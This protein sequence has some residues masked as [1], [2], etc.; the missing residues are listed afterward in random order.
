MVVWND[1][2]IGH[3]GESSRGTARVLQRASLSR[4]VYVVAALLGVVLQGHPVIGVLQRV[5]W[6]RVPP[7]YLVLG[8]QLDV[9]GGAIGADRSHAVD[10][11]ARALL[12]NTCLGQNV[13]LVELAEGSVQGLVTA[14][15]GVLVTE[16][17]L[18]HQVGLLGQQP[19]VVLARLGLQLR[20][21]GLVRV[22]LVRDVVVARRDGA[23]LDD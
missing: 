7:H 2:V 21:R 22:R 9:L 1:H 11:L 18:H 13:A 10:L 8:S 6:T 4:F 14:V 19:E 15:A 5:R 3:P 12:W 17:Q 20:D 16:D 23:L